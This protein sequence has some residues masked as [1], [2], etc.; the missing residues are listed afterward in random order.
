MSQRPGDWNSVPG[1]APLGITLSRES[2]SVQ[3]NMV[4]IANDGA[5]V[6]AQPNKI[7]AGDLADWPVVRKTYLPDSWDTRY[8]SVIAYGA[9]D[10]TPVRS[11]LLLA[12]VGEGT[13]LYLALDAD[14]AIH[15]MNPGAYRLVSNLLSLPK[16]STRV[17]RLSPDR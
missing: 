6:L 4:R 1:L 12:S 2:T 8:Q 10:S 16:Y 9:A 13:Y 3:L 11:L 14:E 17:R 15:R 7:V 5:T